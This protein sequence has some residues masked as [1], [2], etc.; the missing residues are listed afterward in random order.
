MKYAFTAQQLADLKALLNTMAT[1]YQRGWFDAGHVYHN[2]SY[3]KHRQ[4]GADMFFAL[5]GL[6]DAM[7]SG[8]NQHYFAPLLKYALAISRKYISHFADQ[9]GVKIAQDDSDITFTNGATISFHGGLG[10]R[11][12]GKHGNAYLSEYAWANHPY[13]LYQDAC[14]VS[15]HERYRLTLFTSVSPSDEAFAVWLDSQAKGFSLV[16]T[17]NDSVAKGGIWDALDVETFK[18]ESSPE[19]FRQQY[20]CE[21]PQQEAAE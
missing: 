9:V 2:R 7:E 8:R 21:W 18:R 5:E 13:A 11:L 4:A 10:L 6:I 17:I 3:T 15:K 16:H 14:S 20:L 1:P 19:E 12:S